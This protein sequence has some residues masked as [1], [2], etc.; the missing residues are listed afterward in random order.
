MPL[1]FLDTSALVKYYRHEAGSDFVE[2]LFRD[3][4]AQRLISHIATVELE[5]AFATMVRTGQI[6]RET[7]L[8]AR[9][10]I[11]FDLSRRNIIVAAVVDMHFRIARRLLIQYGSVH[12]LRTLD[13]CNYR[14][15]WG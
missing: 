12:G 3:N 6:D 13:H 9:R 8:I 10:R 11:E 5:S 7:A 4:G 1:F 15:Q 14:W 2:Q